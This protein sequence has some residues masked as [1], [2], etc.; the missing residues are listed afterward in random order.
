MDIP[1]DA[2]AH[3]NC[4]DQQTEVTLRWRGG[5]GEDR[6]LLNIVLSKKG[7]LVDLTGVFVRLHEKGGRRHE[8]TSNMAVGE[9]DVLSWPYR[10]DNTTESPL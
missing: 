1:K 8:L 2:E 6:N 10:S 5:E 7:R 4:Q 9:K 3:G